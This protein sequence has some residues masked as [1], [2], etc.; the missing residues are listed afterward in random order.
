MQTFPQFL[1]LHGD[2][3]EKFVTDILNRIEK[4]LPQ[5]T[6]PF[7][8]NIWGKTSL[9]LLA[10]S[11]DVKHANEVLR[12]LGQSPTHHHSMD[13]SDVIGWLVEEN[14]PNVAYYFDSRLIETDQTRKIK[15][16]ALI[17]EDS[18]QMLTTSKITM[19]EEKIRKQIF[20]DKEKDVEGRVK[21]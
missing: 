10:D 13:I 4:G 12:I 11:D 15:K 2:S 1:A 18:G 9:H 6:I 5:P 16:G 7:A 17:D 20:R 21:V 3:M 14:L 19:N 8:R